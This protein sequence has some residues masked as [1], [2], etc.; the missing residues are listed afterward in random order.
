MSSILSTWWQLVVSGELPGEV[1][2]SLWR[3]FAGYFI[4]VVLG[5]ASAC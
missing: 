3:M 5:V 4:G 2:P 1:L